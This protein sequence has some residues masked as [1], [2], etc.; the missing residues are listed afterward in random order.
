MIC[1]SPAL[2]PDGKRASVKVSLPVAFDPAGGLKVRSVTL[3]AWVVD[4]GR[5]KLH[6]LDADLDEN[7]EG[8]RALTNTLYGGDRSHRVRQEILLGV[9]G[10]RLLRALGIRPTVCH[11]NEGHSAFLAIERIRSRMKEHGISFAA[12]R[13]ASAAGNVFTTHTPVPAGNDVF[14]KEMVVPYLET[15]A[16]EMG[17]PGADL[18]ALGRAAPSEA[19]SD[20]S[21][22]VLAIRTADAYNGVSELHGRE[23]RAMWSSLWPDVPVDDV[24]IGSVTNGVHPATWIAPSLAK[25]YAKRD[26]RR[27]PRQGRRA[28][29]LGPRA[30]AAGRR[31][32]AARTRPG[33]A[34]S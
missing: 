34:T 30:R 31:A 3:Q 7:A 32:V 27:L 25:L 17:V 21:M 19:G 10:V 2:A 11:M 33:C 1:R 29:P 16:R 18:L 22:P 14:A 12:A 15:L 20:F 13:E 4:V 8:D 9:G 24:P 26:G 28:G 23:A 5:V 6:L